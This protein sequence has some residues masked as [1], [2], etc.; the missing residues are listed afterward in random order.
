MHI[1]ITY[2]KT[3]NLT[4]QG[5]LMPPFSQVATSWAGKGPT[6]LIKIKAGHVT[7]PGRFHFWSE[8]LEDKTKTPDTLGFSSD[9]SYIT[10][11]QCNIKEVDNISLV[12]SQS[13]S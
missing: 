1:L 12:P 4:V 6:L 9:Y 11:S 5:D 3:N 10:V 13:K 7:L 2:Y 8:K